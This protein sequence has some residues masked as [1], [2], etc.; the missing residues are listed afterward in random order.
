MKFACRAFDKAGREVIEHIDAATAA[1]AGEAARRKGLFVADVK[2]LADAQRDDRVRER[3][4]TMT[5]LRNIT[6]FTRQLGVL[7]STGTPMLD[8]IASLERQ[9]SEGPWKVVLGDVRRRVEQGDPLSQAMEAHPGWFDPICRSLIAA[10]ESSGSM[11]IVL[12]RLSSLS[13][14]QVKIHSNIR[15]AMV[16][17][18]MLTMMALSV[19]TTMVTFVLPRFEGLFKTLDAP[20]PPSTK[21]VMGLGAILREEWPWVLGGLIFLSVVLWSFFTTAKGRDVR[22]V[23]MARAPFFGRIVRSLAAARIA[24]VLGVLLEGRVQMLD[25]LALTRAAAGNVLY[26]ALIAKAQDAVTRGDGV[27]TAFRDS[28]LLPPS[29]A[30]AVRSG[31]RNGQVGRVL[32][33]VADSMDEDNE[34]LVRTLT[35]IIEPLILIVMGAVVGFM[36]IGMFLPLFDLTSAAGNGGMHGGGGVAP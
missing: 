23:L 3:V 6:A 21:V 19:T 15:G 2:P 31:E 17:P 4:G 20:L 25:A 34:V 28:D 36:A 35:T 30:E 33:T 10:G 29:F 26:T 22:D 1:D 27:S 24:R 32:L 12:S 9:A 14:Q 5:R 7:T 16:Y 8:A 11:E 13:R 18:A